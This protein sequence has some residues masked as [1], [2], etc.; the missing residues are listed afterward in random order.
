[1]CKCKNMKKKIVA[2][3]QHVFTTHTLIFMHIKQHPLLSFVRSFALGLDHTNVRNLCLQIV[4]RYL[5]IVAPRIYASTHICGK[6]ENL[7]IKFYRKIVLYKCTIL[8]QIYSC[9]IISTIVH[10]YKYSCC[11]QRK[12]L[13]DASEQTRACFITFII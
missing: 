7:K 5:Y 13:W 4:H 11:D 6:R 10:I 12:C 1:M 2:F 9:I 3:T 8:V